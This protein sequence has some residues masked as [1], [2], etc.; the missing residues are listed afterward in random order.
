MV[1]LLYLRRFLATIAEAYNAEKEATIRQMKVTFVIFT[2]KI[3]I[4][5][6]Q[7]RKYRGLEQKVRDGLRHQLTIQ[8][9]SCQHDLEARSKKL[10]VAFTR[11]S[12]MRETLAE[13][14][15]RAH[16]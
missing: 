10:V 14:I 13:C 2:L 11:A 12:L 15:K 7:E 16:T 4:R 1:K 5:R 9:L 6:R 3:K 8:A